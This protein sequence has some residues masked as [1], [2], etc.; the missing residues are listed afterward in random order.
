MS[1]TFER[2]RELVAEDLAGVDDVV[3]A[4]FG[5]ENDDFYRVFAGPSVIFD[6]DADP[7]QIPMD[8]PVTLVDKETGAIERRNMIVC[9]DLL[10]TMQPIG[11]VPAGV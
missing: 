4:E 8:V 9:F 10:D 7:A 3:I 11:D 1:I 6:D 5:Q 2:A